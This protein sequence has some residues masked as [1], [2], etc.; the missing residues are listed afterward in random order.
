VLDDLMI[1]A[2]GNEM[3][4]HVKLRAHDRAQSSLQEAVEYYAEHR[5]SNFYLSNPSPEENAKY[6]MKVAA[7]S[8]VNLNEIIAQT[9]SRYAN[10]KEA[11]PAST[12]HD[13]QRRRLDSK[14]ANLDVLK[15]QIDDLN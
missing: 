10:Q 3:M 11:F 7:W 13:Y 4:L 14:I 9:R 5:Y 2:G 8:E 6:L 15:S 1:W 12:D